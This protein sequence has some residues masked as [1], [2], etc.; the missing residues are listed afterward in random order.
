VARGAVQ[1]AASASHARGSRHGSARSLTPSLGDGFAPIVDRILDL[2]RLAGNAAVA[3]ML[4]VQRCGGIPCDCSQ[5]EKDAVQRKTGSDFIIRG[6]FPD[7]ANPENKNKLFFDFNSSAPDGAELKKV[8]ALAKPPN[9]DLSLHGFASEEG[10]KSGNDPLI[11]KRIAA[12]DQALAGDQHTGAREKVRHSGETEG[13]IDYRAVRVVEVVP[14]GNGPKSADCTPNPQCEATFGSAIT[15]AGQDVS[16]AL[17]ALAPCSKPQ[18][19]PTCGQVS[20]AMKGAFSSDDEGTAFEVF[21]G[22]LNL[23]DHFRLMMSQAGHTCTSGCDAQCSGGREANT[24]GRKQGGGTKAH[25]FLCPPFGS[26]TLITPAEMMIHE[27]AHG[28]AGLLAEDL[29]YAQGRMFSLLHPDITVKNADSYMLFVRLLLTGARGA[30][31][32]QDVIGSGFSDQERLDTRKT[33]AWMP[34]IL[35]LDANNVMSGTYEKIKVAVKAGTW[36]ADFDKDGH[37]ML[38]HDVLAPRFQMTSPPDVKE[39]DQWKVAAIADRYDQLANVFGGPLNVRK[40]SSGGVVWEPGPSHRVSVG[41]AFLSAPLPTRVRQMVTALIAADPNISGAHKPAFVDL[42]FEIRDRTG[43]TFAA[44]EGAGSTK[45]SAAVA[46]ASKPTLRQ[47]DSGPE[48]AALQQLL[49]GAGAQPQLVADGLFGRRTRGA[50]QRLQSA[51]SLDADGIVGPLTWG[52]L[53][54]QNPASG[55]DAGNTWTSKA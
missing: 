16:A 10:G 45:Q 55:I 43:S 34:E 4:T 38:V 39:E 37:A 52:L 15:Q 2:Q 25:V 21:A 27:G 32:P 47:N 3:S 26:S 19:D 50:V 8:A 9:A 53:S 13:N 49:N 36:G 5:A 11:D 31:G 30:V 20:A 29:A 24:T 1:R 44:T 14:L 23:R 17:S 35:S 33:I 22:L 12:V 51:N 54:K 48:V 7:A 18:T 41:P 46:A 40:R 6:K 42:I 28:A